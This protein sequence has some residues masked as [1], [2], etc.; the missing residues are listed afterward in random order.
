MAKCDQIQQR[1]REELEDME[2]QLETKGEE[3][4]IAK[5]ISSEMERK[6]TTVT[7]QLSI[8]RNESKEE[9]DQQQKLLQL[10]QEEKDHL[11]KQLEEQNSKLCSTESALS[12]LQNETHQALEMNQATIITLQDKLQELEQKKCELLNDKDEKQFKINVEMNNLQEEIR[13][14]QEENS[15]IC[16]EMEAANVESAK[17]IADLQ[18]QIHTLEKMQYKKDQQI[19]ETAK[20]LACSQ[21]TLQTLQEERN[22]LQSEKENHALDVQ[23]R[24]QLLE[25]EVTTQK[26][27]AEMANN[28]L[29]EQQD[30][31][32]E[33][34]VELEQKIAL[35][36]QEISPITS[37]HNEQM[38][39]HEE[40]MHQLKLQLEDSRRGNNSAIE[41]LHHDLR[42]SGE[43]LLL[44]KETIMDNLEV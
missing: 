32:H 20:S 5:Q 19:A 7:E 39:F 13:S 6:V 43:H 37:E 17:T 22:N 12:N 27:V 15:I 40:E 26:A 44:A 35:L 11:L 38:L 34:E 36:M 24:I 2:Y 21:E 25:Q 9:M 33:L 28:I 23:H 4:Y 8:S 10:A 41:T 18:G 1:C 3:L 16:H 31:A 29:K 14:L 42:Q 30:I